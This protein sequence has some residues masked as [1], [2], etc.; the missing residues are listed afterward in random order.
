MSDPLIKRFEIS[1]RRLLVQVLG[2][3]VRRHHQHLPAQD[4]HSKKFLFIRQDRIGDVLISTPIFALLKKY[5]PS[6]TID[7]LLSTNNHYVLEHDPV[8]RKRWIY[9]KKIIPTIQLLSSIRKEKYDYAI[10]M[11]DNPSA[12]STLLCLFAGAQWNV[13]LSKQNSYIYD[14]IVPMLSRRDTHII[15][16]IAQLILPFGINPDSEEL[17][18]RYYVSKNSEDIAGQFISDYR[19]TKE[20]IIGMNISAGGEARY[21]GI[22]KYRSLIRYLNKRHSD[23]FPL[24]LY[25]PSDDLKA[26]EI[27][28]NQEKA[29]LTPITESFDQFAAF[30][31]RLSFLISPDTSAIHLASAFGIPSLVLYVQS[32][33]ELKIWEPYGIDYETIVT[34]VD[35][36]STISVEEVIRGLEKLFTKV[37]YRKNNVQKSY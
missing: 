33:K 28:F 13:G 4:F 11:M 34:D 1:F 9:I 30:I 17:Q 5:Y 25:H 18:I 2:L 15:H 8:I 37:Q 10:D 27:A 14:I 36:L 31:K 26:K 29:L 24:L 22:E 12:T 21:W 20:K 35:K 23:L 16:R 7:V 6:A 32:N 19:L 3:L